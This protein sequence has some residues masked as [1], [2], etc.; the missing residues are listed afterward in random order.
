[1]KLYII[2]RKRFGNKTIACMTILHICRCSQLV[3]NLLLDRQSV[4][5]DKRDFAIQLEIGSIT[6][7]FTDY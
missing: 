2:V 3:L 6:V 7:K 5:A 4:R 1:M